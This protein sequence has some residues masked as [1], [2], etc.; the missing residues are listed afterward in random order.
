M[1]RSESVDTL[2][3]EHIDWDSDALT[4]EEQGHKGDQTGENKFA[5]H[6]YANPIQP[7]KCPVLALAVLFSLFPIEA[8]GIRFFLEQTVKTGLERFYQKWSKHS[9]KVRSKGLVVQLMI[10][11][12]IASEKEAV[13]MH[14]VRSVVQRLSQ[15]SLGWDRAWAS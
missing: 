2:M 10:L 11:A 9:T 6:I 7:H 4:I 8:S 3:M 12:R 15:Y 1:S 13:P 5:K 14:L